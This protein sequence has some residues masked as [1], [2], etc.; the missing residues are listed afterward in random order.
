MIA[1]A[2]AAVVAFVFAWLFGEPALDG[3][4]A[5]ED[6]LA[7]A[8]GEEGGEALVSRGVQS[9]IGLFVALLVYGIAFGGI[10]GIVCATTQGRLGT[11]KY[12]LPPQTVR[13]DEDHV[14]RLWNG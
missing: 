6:A 7:A 4:I 11:L 8:A 12:F 10:L 1:G 14:A 2:V 5:Y 9:T 3:G 13:H